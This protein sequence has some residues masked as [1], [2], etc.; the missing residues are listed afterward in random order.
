VGDVPAPPAGIGDE[1]DAP[2]APAP[3]EVPAARDEDEGP[4]ADQASA[5]S[6]APAEGGA[7]TAEVP[8]PA[9]PSDATAAPEPSPGEPPA[10][11]PSET[12][13]RPQS[14]ASEPPPAEPRESTPA[15]EAEAEPAEPATEPPG[16]QTT[17][18]AQ[19]VPEA[20]PDEPAV[21]DA[22][23]RRLLAELDKISFQFDSETGKV[24]RS[25]LMLIQQQAQRTAERL[26]LKPDGK[27]S[28]VMGIRLKLDKKDTLVDV[29][30][31]TQLNVPG[32][33][34]KPVVIW[35]HQIDVADV[36]MQLLLAGR[37]PPALREAIE[38]AFQK[39]AADRRQAAEQSER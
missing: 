17:P 22:D 5:T 36:P 9:A 12:E 31:A 16:E 38:D 34:D 18:A 25:V 8:P 29:S 20:E 1:S 4:D 3:P 19:A 37:V 11:A 14:D 21:S 32:P 33:K 39:F 15:A 10:D 7:P 13:P 6:E 24:P 2:G 27:K 28:R 26:G 23:R 35:S 30:M